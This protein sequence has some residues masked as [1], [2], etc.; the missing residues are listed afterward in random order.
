MSN[1]Y[2]P[3][4]TEVSELMDLAEEQWG[5]FNAA[6]DNHHEFRALIGS[7]IGSIGNAD[8]FSAL[9]KALGL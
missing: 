8:A 4:R 7:A 9:R 1:R 6:Y 5:G 3:S 2:F